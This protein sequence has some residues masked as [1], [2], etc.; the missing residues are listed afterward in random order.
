MLT[1]ARTEAAE[2]LKG[3]PVSRSAVIRRA[4]PDEWMLACDLPQCAEPE[5]VCEFQAKAVA[6]GWETELRDGWVLLDKTEL[7]TMPEIPI[8]YPDGEMGCVLSLI[9]RHP[10]F[11]KGES[12]LRNLA[13]ATELSSTAAEII[14]KKLHAEL[15]TRLRQTPRT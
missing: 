11:L 7:L 15:A 13:K 5:I 9:S 1:R 4:I 3:L 14:F 6:E 2:L 12:L 10:E 8:S